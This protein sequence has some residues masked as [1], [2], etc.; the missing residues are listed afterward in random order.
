MQKLPFKQIPPELLQGVLDNPYEG[1][2]IIDQDGIVR[3]FSKANE[4]LYGITV[5]EAIGQHIEAVIP[6]SRLHIVVR[7]GKAEIGDTITVKG[8]QVI[9]SRYPIKMNDKI[10]G[11]VGKAIFHDMK[12]FVALKD[13]IKKLQ[14]HVKRYARG[15][16]EIHNARYTF[17]D[18][19]GKSAL[20]SRTKKM[21][22]QMA[23]FEIPILLLGES[24]TGK[25]LFAH[26]I[27]QASPRSMHPFIRINCASIPGD[28][29]ESELFGYEP[30]TFTGAV[31]P[32]KPGKFELADKGTI[33]LDEIGE[34]P[35]GMQAKLLR[36]LQ[37]KE[38]ERLGARKPK[39]VDFRV[40]AATNK[41]MEKRINEGYFRTDLY[42]RLN[43]V[44]I[45]LP[46]LREIK[47]DIPLLVKHF[48]S[49][50][51]KSASIQA[52]E[53]LP[54]VINI[55]TA[56]DWPGNTREL[57]NVIERAL[58]L[59]RNRQITTQHIP[60]NLMRQHGISKTFF[61]SSA[62]LSHALGNTERE[63]IIDALNTANGNKTAAARLLNIHRTTLYYKLKKYE[64]VPF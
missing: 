50:I 48:I 29:F 39:F 63:H 56:Y 58:Y 24:G 10:I 14:S 61:D 21:S 51:G 64:I 53:I 54:E 62:T 15:I 16:R 17:E 22:R 8:R 1:A 36:V 37:E 41:D 34:L 26:S 33:F 20:L 30:G 46:P 42:Y 28:L 52:S 12:A 49:T 55:F 59:C 7:T 57:K 13:K 18:I 6:G 5:R 60:E 27:H 11:A 44:S 4:S 43:A 40:I 45:N 38:V 32:G 25:E 2:I 31:K 3:H 9:V 47:S 19:V 35:L 23:S